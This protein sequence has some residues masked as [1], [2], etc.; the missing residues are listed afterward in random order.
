MG[1]RPVASILAHAGI[2]AACLALSGCESEETVSEP[3]KSSS[4]VVPR[5][6]YVID[7]E[8]GETRAHFTDAEGRTTTL[9]SGEKVPVALPQGFT[10]FEGATVIKNTRVEQAD[11]TI[12]LL[13]LRS[14]ASRGEMVDFY[15]K[16]AEAAGIEV[17]LELETGPMTMIGGTAPDGSS[18]SFTAKRDGAATEAQLSVG[19]GLR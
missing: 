18:F 16:E 13:E 17:N 8:T 7:A 19:R 3:S 6:N 15:R 11:G 4:A 5:G 9:R 12:V 14:P 1:M 10:V 2:A